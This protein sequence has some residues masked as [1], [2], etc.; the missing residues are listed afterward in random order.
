M[1]I[2]V[3][4]ETLYLDNSSID[5]QILNGSLG[6]KTVKMLKNCPIVFGPHRIPL[7]DPIDPKLCLLTLFE[8]NLTVDFSGDVKLGDTK[9]NIIA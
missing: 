5:D 7:S 4:G 1:E 2:N 3:F 9:K 6:P 8:F